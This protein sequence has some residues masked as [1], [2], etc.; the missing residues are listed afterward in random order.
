MLMLLFQPEATSK[1][2]SY[3]VGATTEIA[4]SRLRPSRMMACAVDGS[5]SQVKKAL[6][7][8]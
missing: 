4:A 8:W 2:T 7:K 6:K 1:L 5:P 3:P